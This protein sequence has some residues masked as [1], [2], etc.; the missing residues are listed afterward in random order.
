M[1]AGSDVQQREAFV[2]QGSLDDFKGSVDEQD[3]SQLQDNDNDVAAVGS[4][5]FG[6]CR[7]R[8]LQI[9]AKPICFMIVLNIYC[10]VEG[11]IVSGKDSVLEFIKAITKR[12]F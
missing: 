1:A 9:F 12:L 10:F 7:P 3:N 11:T 2:S 8:W 5:G 6:P 4:C